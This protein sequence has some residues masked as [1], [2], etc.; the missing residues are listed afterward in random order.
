MHPTL[1]RAAPVAVAFV[2]LAAALCVGAL[3]AR[4]ELAPDGVVTDDAYIYLRYAKNLAAGRGWV[5]N[6][7]EERVEGASSPLWTLLAAAATAAP[8]D[9]RGALVALAVVLV[10]AALAAWLAVALDRGGG[11]DPAATAAAAVAIAVFLGARPG[12]AVW[13]AASG[14]DSGLWCAALVAAAAT[15]VRLAAT[16]AGRRHELAAAAAQVGLALT[17]PE[18][19]VVGPGAI[20]AAALFA[21]RPGR[22]ARAPLAAWAATGLALVAWRRS[23]FGWP[24]PNTYYAK[25]DSDLGARLA[26]GWRWLGEAA[27]DD[28]TLAPLA[29]AA[30][31]A[32]AVLV[33]RR[34]RRGPG[35]A[36]APA[37]AVTAAMTLVAPALALVE[38]GDYFPGARPLV[39]F[40]PFAATLVVL[41]VGGWLARR[42]AHRRAVAAAAAALAGA[43]VLAYFAAAPR[44]GRL[45]TTTGHGVDFATAR[46]GLATAVELERLFPPPAAPPRAGVLAAGALPYAWRGPSRDLLGL[47][48]V[49]MAHA[50]RARRGLHGHAAFDRESFFAAPPEL[51]FV[52]DRRCRGSTAERARRRLAFR[53]A[54]DSLDRDPRFAERYLLVE[55][56][57]ADGGPGLCTFA[58]R[59]WLAAGAGGVTGAS[60]ATGATGASWRDAAAAGS[61]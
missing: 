25:L 37:V 55:W 36:G 14:M 49:A 59:D 7:G 32:L 20:A 54:L 27:G 22:V 42:L 8:D 61:P 29:L 24:L 44:W 39:P 9:P 40:R 2:I 41:V 47:N 46:A 48:D 51:V 56:S 5:W 52:G 34:V 13:T 17:R 21:A 50:A 60:G 58:R 1:R 28:P 18:A 6:P 31:A 3:A 33:A 53:V 30:A 15:L 12:F 19:I 10:A 43:G 38:G 11:A 4:R 23:T 57:G 45:A 26:D 16:G 35:D